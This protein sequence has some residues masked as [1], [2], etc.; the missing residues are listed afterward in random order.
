LRMVGDGWVRVMM[1]DGRDLRQAV[2]CSDEAAG[3]GVVETAT[4]A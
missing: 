4:L 3:R 2:E 1:R